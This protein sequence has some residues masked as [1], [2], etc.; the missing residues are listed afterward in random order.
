[1]ST[2][3]DMDY[4]S[5][6]IEDERLAASRSFRCV[7]PSGL[8]RITRL[9]AKSLG[10]PMAWISIVDH[11]HQSLHGCVGVDLA[12]TPRQGSLGAIA[13]AGEAILVVPDVAADR[14]SGGEP[15]EAAQGIRF[16]AAAPLVS[17]EGHRIGALCVMDDAPREGLSPLGAEMLASFA[18]MTMEYLELRRSDCANAA[19]AGFADAAEYAF[20]AVDGNGLITFANRAAEAMFGYRQHEFL[21]QGI[22]I[23]I[24]EPF[25]KA[26]KA[27]LARIAAGGPSKMTGRTIE[28]TAQR[29]D[30]GH[31]PVEFSMSLW[32]NRNGVGVG[33]MMRDISEWRARDARLVQM[34]HHDKLTGLT[35]RALF[36]ER[37]EASLGAGWR[38]TVM[39][40]NL[41]GFK[42]VN[43]S[44]GHSTGD[45]LLQ[46]V[47]L[48]LPSCVP[49][50][51][52]VARFGGDEFALL[53]PDTG[54]PLKVRACAA[55]ILAAFQVP[56][57]VGGHTFHVGLSMGAAIGAGPD[58]ASDELIAD[59]DL[60]LYQA[61]RDGR[62][63]FRLFEPP[64]RSA[65]IARRTLHDE[66]TRAFEASEL[67]LH[68]QPQVALQT[69]GIVG[70]ESLLRWQH[71]ERGLLLPGV[72]LDALE[73]HPL[74]AMIGQW[75]ID[76]ACRQAAWW[77]GARL[78]PLRVAV[79]L[80]GAQLQTGTLA[81]EVAA[82]LSRHNLPP[83]ALEIEVT[84][85]I[86]LQA[87]DAFLDPIRELHHHGVAI[88]FDDFGTGYASL[89]SLK[90]FPL[91]RL[92][93]DR[94][95]VRDVLTDRHDAEIIRAVLGM[96]Q[97]FGLDVIA[98]GIE[99]IE[100][101]SVLRAM[102]CREGQGYLYGK[103]MAPEALTA[104]VKERL[105]NGRE[106]SAA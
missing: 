12:R 11:A 37:L 106:S 25:R 52:V 35:N 88:A 86:A 65:V 54:D 48:R 50:E 101:E 27:G 16:Y 99:T 81:R 93:I 53:M 4:I 63:C 42:D 51:T 58:T 39:L 24:P 70:V 45:G 2:L 30:G 75:I 100:Q 56:F 32:R 89:S 6:D 104:L 72:F 77:Q 87:E 1:M 13:M 29:R 68:Y 44:L 10:M 8:D 83:Q 31:F 46:A 92:K 49:P 60:A 95:F 94:S 18:A 103:A 19:S 91:T 17:T 22:E 43:D 15:P 84:E 55:A 38:A 78:P 59:A 67:V 82:S 64:M 3:A 47:A 5:P 9:A 28:L 20:V 23:V 79:N 102:G 80:F 62:R 73:A 90:R 76:E 57:H 98:E 97:S 85:R 40:L 71:P 26:H 96:A 74:A 61:R 66:L 105:G 21:G 69:G 33:A 14:R 36:D 41:D 34:A 7:D